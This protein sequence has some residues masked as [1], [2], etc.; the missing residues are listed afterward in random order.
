M[1]SFTIDFCTCAA[2]IIAKS[3]SGTNA[4]GVPSAIRESKPYSKCSYIDRNALKFSRVHE[5][6]LNTFVFLISYVF[7]GREKGV[8]GIPKAQISHKNVNHIS[9]FHYPF[10]SSSSLYRIILN[11]GC[12]LRKHITLFL[13]SNFFGTKRNVIHE[14][15]LIGI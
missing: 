3:R 2:A 1:H 5:I 4:N 14:K 7:F 6:E 13:L 11:F 12:F 15:M 9:R 10:Y 8:E